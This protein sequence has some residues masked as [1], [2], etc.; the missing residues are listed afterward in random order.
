MFFY[1][2]KITEIYPGYFRQK[3]IKHILTGKILFFPVQKSE[4]AL[5]VPRR[6]VFF[7]GSPVCRLTGISNANSIIKE[8][9]REINID[10]KLKKKPKSKKALF[11]QN[12]SD[13]IQKIFRLSSCHPKTGCKMSK[14]ELIY[15]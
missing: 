1:S 8:L 3:M 7:P 6:V 14:P 4:A 2:L 11:R 13:L 12:S 5:I 15:F 9:C 10:Q